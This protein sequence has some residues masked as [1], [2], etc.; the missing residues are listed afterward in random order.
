[1]AGTAIGGAKARGTNKEPYGTDFY[2]RQG[3]KGGSTPTTKPKGFAAMSPE[4]RKAAGQKGGS[5]GK[6]KASVDTVSYPEYS[7]T[8]ETTIYFT[9]SAKVRA[10][11]RTLTRRTKV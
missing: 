3:A 2:K 6:R 7:E 4:K 8:Y 1:M 9:K 11:L 5:R 10:L